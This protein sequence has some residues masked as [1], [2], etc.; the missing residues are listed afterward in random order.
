MYC[1]VKLSQVFPQW[2][3]RLLLL[4]LFSNR[5]HASSH[6]DPH[7]FILALQTCNIIQPA[8]FYEMK[9]EV[10]LIYKYILH[11][12]SVHDLVFL[13]TQKDVKTRW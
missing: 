12:H 3:F 7:G 13:V 10:Q 1:A 2:R 8:V 9:P 4:Y 5:L 11:V 6:N